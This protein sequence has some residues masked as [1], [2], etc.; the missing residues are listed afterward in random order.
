MT[1]YPFLKINGIKIGSNPCK[2]QLTFKDETDYFIW[3]SPIAIEM[4]IDTAKY[5]QMD[6]LVVK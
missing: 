6:Q 5:I 4:V 2:L 1:M 3:Y